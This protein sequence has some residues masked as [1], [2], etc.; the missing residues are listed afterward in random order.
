LAQPRVK[1]KT[2]E[3][4]LTE[5]DVVRLLKACRNKREAFVVGGLVFTGMRVSEFIHM[6]R[7]WIRDG[8]IHIPRSKKCSC[9]ECAKKGGIWTPKTPSSIRVIPIVPEIESLFSEFFSEYNSVME[10]IP[11][12]QKAHYIIRDVGKRINKKVFPHSLRGTFATILAKKG[13]NPFEI[14]DVMGWS[15]IDVA[16]SYINMVGAYVK[17][18]FR[19][20]W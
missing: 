1:P 14:K 7:S 4:I 16:M 13:F 19:Q 9:S 20:K 12:R 2:V 6:D 15:K 5:R 3:N 18:A 17:E 8:A 11:N 10:L